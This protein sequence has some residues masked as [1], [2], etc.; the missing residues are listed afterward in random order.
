MRRVGRRALDEL[1]VD[2]P[3]LLQLAAAEVRRGRAARAPSRSGRRAASAAAKRLLRVV[4]LALLEQLAA[5]RHGLLERF[6]IDCGRHHALLTGLARPRSA[7]SRT[8]SRR[9][10]GGL[11]QI[12]PPRVSRTV[13][14]VTATAPSTSV[15]ATSAPPA[16][17]RST[18]SGAG[19]PNEFATPHEITASA[20]WVAATNAAVDEVGLPWCGTLTTST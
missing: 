2:R 14:I 12:G 9:S 16:R 13:T 11:S 20:G 5:A 17:Q 19:N 7:A 18:T 3:R 15:R 10:Q 6:S 1:L 4:E 8:G